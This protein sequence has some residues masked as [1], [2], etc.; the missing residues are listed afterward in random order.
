MLTQCGQNFLDKYTTTSKVL[1]RDT[2]TKLYNGSS[3]SI[4][5]PILRLEN[6]QFKTK[7]LQMPTTTIPVDWKKIEMNNWTQHTS[8]IDDVHVRLNDGAIPTLILLP[9][10]VEGDDPFQLYTIVVCACY[11]AILELHNKI[12]L[13]VGSLE[14]SSRPEWVVYDPVAKSFCKNNGQVTIPDIGK[15]N[16]SPPRHIGELEFH[17]PR[18]M[19]N[20]LSMPERLRNIE[21]ILEKILGSDLVVGEGDLDNED[22]KNKNRVKGP[23]YYYH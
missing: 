19:F 21:I 5:I 7:I 18:M 6:I 20:Y 15:V 14:I 12:G 17:D 23:N 10:P 22:K 9:S 8:Q 13:E 4:P 1:V 16:A 2:P 3:T 11:N